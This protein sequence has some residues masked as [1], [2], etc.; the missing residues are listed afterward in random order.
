VGF[1]LGEIILLLVV[2]LIVVGPRRL[3][4]LMRTAGQ[5]VSRLRRMSMDLRSQSGID[6][7]IRQEGLEPHLSELRS[8]SRMNVV[9]TL[10]APAVG[11]AAAPMAPRP[12]MGALPR[13][14]TEPLRER[15]YPL[16]GCD[17]YGAM[18]D[19]ALP[20]IPPRPHAAVVLVG[21]AETPP[22]PPVVDGGGETP[23]VDGGAETPIVVG[24]AETPLSPPVLDGAE[25]PAPVAAPA[26]AAPSAAPD[27]AAA[28]APLALADHDATPAA[29]EHAERSDA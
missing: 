16:A 25:T 18:P 4:G 7:L 10:I 20:Y 24:G 9:D 17:A 5:W 1:S 3:P 2:G 19:D 11:G 14:R 12:A 13:R 29:G 28:S 21:G 26:A 6:D 22:N 8:L 27:A 23:V 15:E